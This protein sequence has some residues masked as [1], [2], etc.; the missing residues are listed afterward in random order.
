MS[1][2]ALQ[3]NIAQTLA[4]ELP[5]PSIV[6]TLS[7]A[8]E[9]GA[10]I[11][12]A[13]PNHTKLEKIDGESLLR[14][15]RRTKASTTLTDHP[16]FLQY[17]NDHKELATAVWCQ[18]DPV[19]YKLAF[20]AV[21]D[22]IGPAMPAWRSHKAGFV[23]TMSNEWTAWT[24]NNRKVMSQVEFAYF[25]EEHEDDISAVD[26]YPS[27]LD[28]MKMAT[29]FEARQDQGIKS[30]VRL[31]NGGVELAYV[32]NDDAQTIEK[33]RLFE[34]FKIGIP[35]FRGATDGCL[36]DARLR[37]RTHQGKATFWYELVRPDRAHEMA[38]Q[39]MIK[40]VRD[41]LNEV[42]VLMGQCVSA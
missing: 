17:V 39:T 20:N 13:V 33:M 30:A 38:A 32:S 34:K 40:T 25:I 10:V 6:Q 9:D 42:P 27:S 36:L 22:E 8:D 28:M 24:E 12:V 41:G 37:Y 5:K 2:Q 1:L 16:S 23:P 7:T 15:P 31:Q 11:Y 14:A 29:E 26:G 21:I 4:R 3:E 35:V 18:F 19:T